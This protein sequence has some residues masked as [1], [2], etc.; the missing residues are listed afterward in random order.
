M[1]RILLAL[2]MTGV[3][4]ALIPHADRTSFS[5]EKDQPWKYALLTAPFDIPVMRDSVSLLQVRDSI[6]KH[7]G[8]IPGCSAAV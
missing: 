1:L 2:V 5:Y 4:I 8:R 7:S 3:V 6:E